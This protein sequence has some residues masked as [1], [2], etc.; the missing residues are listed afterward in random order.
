MYDHD[1]RSHSGEVA[2]PWEAEEW[3]G[4]QVVDEHLPKVF[5]LHVSELR[6]C[7]GPVERQLQHVVPPHVTLNDMVRIIV[8]ER[9]QLGISFVLMRGQNIRYNLCCICPP[10]CISNSAKMIHTYQHLMMSQSNL[11]LKLSFTGSYIDVMLITEE[12]SRQLQWISIC[13][14]IFFQLFFY[15]KAQTDAFT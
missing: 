10:M 13:P 2:G 12:W 5:S 15:N 8:P 3:D 11:V 4:G 9:K 6:D 14:L 1:E 7:Q